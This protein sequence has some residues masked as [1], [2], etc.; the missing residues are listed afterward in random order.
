MTEVERSEIDLES[1]KKVL[2]VS[3][4]DQ[5]VLI[6]LFDVSFETSFHF[7]AIGIAAVIG[8]DVAMDIVSRSRPRGVLDL[9]PLTFPSPI[10]HRTALTAFFHPSSIFTPPRPFSPCE[11]EF[12]IGES[13]YEQYEK[14]YS[15]NPVCL[16]T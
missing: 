6:Q 9:L 4:R 8:T 2:A 14:H 13:N 1:R 7:L 16:A 3:I 12:S 10:N 5:C 11:I 15:S